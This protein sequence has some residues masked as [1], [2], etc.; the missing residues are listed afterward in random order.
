M[1]TTV[2]IST[3]QG[4]SDLLGLLEAD[5][6]IILTQADRPIAKVAAIAHAP[7]PKDGRV[8]DMHK[9][10]WVDDGFNEQL[11]ERFWNNRTL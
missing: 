7:I 2:D 3:L 5:N 8:P 10:I 4:L 1:T 11:P 6:E 9:D